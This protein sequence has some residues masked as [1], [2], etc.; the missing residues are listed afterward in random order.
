MFGS[1]VIKQEIKN[2]KNRKRNDFPRSL[3]LT[4]N[5]HKKDGVRSLKIE[6]CKLPE[7][8]DDFLRVFFFTIYNSLDS[9]FW[10]EKD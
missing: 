1:Q 8:E 7:L 6:A 9:K 4:T 5:S 2:D 10:K 3:L